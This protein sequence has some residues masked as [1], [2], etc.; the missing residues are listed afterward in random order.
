MLRLLGF[1]FLVIICVDTAPWGLAVGA[2]L[3][4]AWF[5]TD[6]ETMPPFLGAGANKKSRRANSDEYK[7]L[8][9]IPL[10]HAVYCANC[11]LITNSPNESCRSCGSHSILSVSRLWQLTF[12]HAAAGATK[13]KIDFTADIRGIPATG[14]SEAFDLMVRLGEL[15][16]EL[17]VFHIQVDDAES[18]DATAEREKIEV[19]KHGPR[20]VS[21]WPGTRQRAS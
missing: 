11:D 21:A 17:K 10:V 7:Y 19:V 13:Y 1:V 20:A 9:A 15:G 12:G 14:L 2:I 18:S 8:S 16:G 3:C 6:R 4:V 5:F